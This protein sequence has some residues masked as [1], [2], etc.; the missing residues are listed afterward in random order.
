MIFQYGKKDISSNF[1]APASNKI[2]SVNISFP[3]FINLKILL[4]GFGRKFMNILP[5]VKVV[6]LVMLSLKY[7]SFSIYS[8]SKILDKPPLNSLKTAW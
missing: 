4:F 8:L 1:S 2:T 3:I 6:M 7:F 5:P